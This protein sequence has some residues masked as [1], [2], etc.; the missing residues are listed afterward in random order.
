MYLVVGRR[1]LYHTD[2]EKMAANR[3][4]SKRSYDKYA[5]HSLTLPDLNIFMVTFIV[6]RKREQSTSDDIS[7]ILRPTNGNVEVCGK[8]STT[9]L[10]TKV[11]KFSARESTEVP[12]S[13]VVRT[14]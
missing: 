6:S 7:N 4:K 3:A 11:C 13:I 10:L 1:H 5:V 8:L 12:S 9:F 2:E 14:C